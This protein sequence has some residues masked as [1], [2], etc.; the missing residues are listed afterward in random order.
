MELKQKTKRLKRML[1]HKNSVVME[2]I[3]AEDADTGAAVRAAAI[4]S[5][6]RL[7]FLALN[8]VTILMLTV[9]MAHILSIGG[10]T[11]AKGAMIVAYVTTLPWL[12][13]GFWN[14]I[15]GYLLTS[16]ATRRAH[17]DAD[18]DPLA[19]AY[20]PSQPIN[21]RTAIVMALRNEEAE[22]AF[23]R[24]RA[25][26][27]E[28]LELGVIDHFDFHV[29]SDSDEP[30][31]ASEEERLMAEWRRTSPVLRQLHYRRR[32]NN[33]GYK[34]GNV[35]EFCRRTANDYDFF[36]PLD[37]DSVMS[38]NAVCRLV[39]MLE[40]NPSVG[41]LQTLVVGAPA[42]TFFARAFQ[43]GMRHGMRAYA[44]GSSWW[45]GDCGPYW[46]H[47]A[48]VRMRPFR[49]HCLL[50][51][52]PGTGPLGGHILSHD[53]VEAALMR[54]AGYQVRVLTDDC[55]SWEEN[56]PTLPD[57]VR[58]DLRWCQG[59]M[60]YLQLLT[61]PGLLPVSRLQLVLAIL[62][63]VGSVGWMGF[64]LFGL[65]EILTTG[66]IDDY[67]VWKGLTL[68]AV[69]MAMN[70]APKIMGLLSVLNSDA[71]SAAYGGRWAVIK[72]S[73]LEFWFSILLAP[74]VSF[75]IAVFVI[76]LCFGQRI[77]W[78]AQ[79][80]SHRQVSWREAAIAFL[81]QTALGIVILALLAF[82]APLVLIWAAPVIAGLA[83][84]I[85][86]AVWTA[87]HGPSSWS[88]RNKIYN[89]PEEQAVHGILSRALRRETDIKAAV[90]TI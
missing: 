50:P 15:I 73:L 74:T 13:I 63:F 55:E 53:Q 87:A 19:L 54:R 31:I 90:Q 30:H 39:R 62:M 21:S 47:N 89:I 29:L 71:E 58:R 33:A 48:L 42:R 59:N 64:I 23:T 67:P 27:D 69:V 14:A 26:H 60:Q 1:V 12:S 68:F 80:R 51:I 3:A 40:A 52:L 79:K 20:D 76:G 84:S 86:F 34:A 81:P 44:T 46:G 83:I 82:Y 57:F 16:S 49:D 32:G 72:S 36:L 77:A 5:R 66:Y 9:G 70:L 10:W 28:L 6:R 22:G 65:F 4:L 37:A 35:E 24:F 2:H 7:V 75:A 38:A 25:I 56:P 17:V 43:F 41:I 85:P 88:V 78:S 61:M 18:N 8:L 11:I 45:Q